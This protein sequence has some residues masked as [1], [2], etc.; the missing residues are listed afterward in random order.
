MPNP[1]TCPHALQY[2]SVTCQ[3][4]HISKLAFSAAPT[5]TMISVS[6]Q[7]E[8]C[9]MAELLRMVGEVKQESADR[10]RQNRELVTDMDEFKGVSEQCQV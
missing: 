2:V 9:T 4:S 10:L 8:D 5:K 6:T 1:M 7:T 3:T